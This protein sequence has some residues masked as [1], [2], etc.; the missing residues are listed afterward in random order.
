VYLLGTLKLRHWVVISLYKW[1]LSDTNI[2]INFNV[3][4]FGSYKVSL[5]VH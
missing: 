2:G 4:S 5:H 3:E 1:V